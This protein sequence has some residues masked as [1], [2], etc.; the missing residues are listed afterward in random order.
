MKTFCMSCGKGVEYIGANNKPSSCPFCQNSSGQKSNPQEQSFKTV[1]GFTSRE[2]Y[3][4][5]GINFKRGFLLN[6][7][8]FEEESADQ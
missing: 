2:N 8:S 7:V 3:I 5:E 6:L 1:A 4:I